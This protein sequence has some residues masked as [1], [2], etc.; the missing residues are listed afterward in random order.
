[1]L[2]TVPVGAFILMGFIG[3]VIAGDVVPGAIMLLVVGAP[4]VLLWRPRRNTSQ[5]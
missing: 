4:L 5:K 1:M 3:A 2:I